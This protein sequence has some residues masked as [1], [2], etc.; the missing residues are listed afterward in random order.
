MGEIYE[1]SHLTIATSIAPDGQS[2]FLRTHL[3]R[4]YYLSANVDLFIKNQQLSNIRAR[5]IH[6]ARTLI[7]P[8]PLYERGW[9]FQEHLLP[10][11]LLTFGA[12]V[13]L[14]CREESVCECG[15]GTL[16]N[17]FAGEAA[18]F[19]QTNRTSF[20]KLLFDESTPKE[21]LCHAWNQ[22]IVRPYSSRNFTVETDRLPGISALAL[23]LQ[24][25]MNDQYL[26]GMWKSDLV[27]SLAWTLYDESSCGPAPST[28]IAPSWSWTSIAKQVNFEE[29]VTTSYRAAEV[30]ILEANVQPRTRQNPLG[31]LL[32]GYLRLRGKAIEGKLTTWNNSRDPDPSLHF[33]LGDA[34]TVANHLRFGKGMNL[35]TFIAY[36]ELEHPN[37]RFSSRKSINRSQDPLPYLSQTRRVIVDV[38]C[39]RIGSSLGQV[40]QDGDANE[41]VDTLLVLGYTNLQPITF[42]RVGIATCKGW[43]E[44]ERV[45][46]AFRK[47]FTTREVSIV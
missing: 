30:K 9:T 18:Q 31:N 47:R 34:V 42:Q 19:Q 45:S 10:R 2:G 20:N 36:T 28:Y 39:L 8:L 37:S 14:E 21:T 6:D 16:H 11:R 7:E 25:K 41:E 46:A 43:F 27:A 32:G 40:V 35:D 44:N 5:Q 17:P 26:A 15:H 24:T 1:N 13:S 33:E 3:A 29:N 38:V 12:L 23:K 4:S 22:T